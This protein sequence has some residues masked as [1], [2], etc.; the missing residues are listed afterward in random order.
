MTDK[1]INISRWGKKGKSQEG[2][3][4][5]KQKCEGDQKWE[6]IQKLLR[7]RLRKNK[8][9]EAETWK[10]LK[11]G[12]QGKCPCDMIKTHRIQ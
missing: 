5:A 4:G 8:R 7:N 10:D 12:Q 11:D 3:W 9:N 6:K 2:E 1:K